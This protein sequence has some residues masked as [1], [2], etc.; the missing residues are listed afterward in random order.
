MN[1]RFAV[2]GQISVIRLSGQMGDSLRVIVLAMTAQEQNCPR[3]G[4]IRNIW[5]SNILRPHPT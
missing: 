3:S 4:E 2:E 5:S 1:R